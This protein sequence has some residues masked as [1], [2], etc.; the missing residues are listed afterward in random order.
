MSDIT[1]DIEVTDITSTSANVRIIPSSDDVPY[2]FDVVSKYILT[3]FYNG[4]AAAVVEAIRVMDIPIVVA[5][6][7]IM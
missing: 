3:E 7:L 2:Y 6:L 1:F 4:D 5:T